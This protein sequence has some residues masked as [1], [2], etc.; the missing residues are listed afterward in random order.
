MAP[1]IGNYLP[2]YEKLPDPGYGS[3]IPGHGSCLPGYEKRPDPGYV[4]D[5]PVCLERWDRPA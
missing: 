2:G 3:Y 5:P 4:S 1:C